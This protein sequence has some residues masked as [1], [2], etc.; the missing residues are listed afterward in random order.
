MGIGLVWAWHNTQKMPVWYLIA[1]GRVRALE[2]DERRQTAGRLQQRVIN[3]ASGWRIDRHT[4]QPARQGGPHG[5]PIRISRDED[6][7]LE[8]TWE[9]INCWLSGELPDWI[10]SGMWHFPPFMHDIRMGGENGMLQLGFRLER[11][12]LTGIV[13]LEGRPVFENGQARLANTSLRIGE[14]RVPFEQAGGW[15]EDQIDPAREEQ[16]L[17]MDLLRGKPLDPVWH[18]QRH[19]VRLTDMRVL[20]ESV[21]LVYRLLSDNGE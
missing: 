20:Q 5:Q 14:F 16:R 10:E 17:V 8:L 21:V 7:E 3:A 13:W 6:V 2:P 15:L 4:G 11:G 9:E 19:S 18:D 12:L 1:D